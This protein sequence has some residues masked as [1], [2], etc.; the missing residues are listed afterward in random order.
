MLIVIGKCSL[1]C[2]HFY[3]T[4]PCLEEFDQTEKQPEPVVPA[5]CVH[6]AL[7]SYLMPTGLLRQGLLP[8]G[9]WRPEAIMRAEE[10]S[11]TMLQEWQHLGLKMYRNYLFLYVI[12]IRFIL[13][14]LLYCLFS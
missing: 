8:P 14:I 10:V 1:I 9:L 13:L 5:S 2:I 3:C 6:P 11:S 4:T 7:P 12:I